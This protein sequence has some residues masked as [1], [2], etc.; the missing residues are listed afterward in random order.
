M[1]NWPEVKVDVKSV[2][3]TTVNVTLNW[4]QSP[5]NSENQMADKH[6]AA[7]ATGLDTNLGTMIWGIVQKFLGLDTPIATLDDFKSKIAAIEKIAEFLA[8][9]TQT[10]TDDELVKKA[11]SFL[12]NELVVQVLFMVYQQL[13][14]NPSMA[15]DMTPE[16]FSELLKE[17]VEAGS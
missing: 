5:R 6:V 2:F 17:G 13:V 1:L 14:K 10:T 4:N 8:G 11:E 16:R 15:K 12:A 7:M 9:L 3:K